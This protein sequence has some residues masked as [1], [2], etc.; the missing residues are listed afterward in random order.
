MKIAVHSVGIVAVRRRILP[1]HPNDAFLQ[2]LHPLSN[3]LPGIAE[4]I[5]G[6]D[7][8]SD[9]ECAKRCE[10]ALSKLIGQCL[11]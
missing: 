3:L 11:T 4:M 8:I 9:N 2:S 6:Y 5:I 10:S 7:G 1:V